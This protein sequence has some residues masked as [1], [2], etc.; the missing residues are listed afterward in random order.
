MPSTDG[1]ALVV[2]TSQNRTMS[3]A[4]AQ[5]PLPASFHV[6]GLFAPEITGLAPD[7]AVMV[8]DLVTISSPSW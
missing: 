7:A 3:L 1:S 4:V 6:S 8:T 2:Q 5:V